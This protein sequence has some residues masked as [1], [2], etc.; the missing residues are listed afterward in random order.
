LCENAGSQ[1]QSHTNI[2][3]KTGM[4][5]SGKYGM[6][7]DVFKIAINKCDVLKNE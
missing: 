3:V 5:M 1:K 2:S 7:T 6:M 4:Y